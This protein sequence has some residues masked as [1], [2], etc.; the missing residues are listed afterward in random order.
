[1]AKYERTGN[2]TVPKW[3]LDK[4]IPIL[5]RPD[6]KQADVARVASEHAGRESPWG[7]DSISKF[8]AGTGRTAALT[9][10]ISAALHIPPPFFIAP[11][12]AAASAMTLIVERE[13]AKSDAESNTLR[14]FDRV[15]EK[16]MRSTAVDDVRRPVVVSV[17]HG[18]KTG[19]GGRAVRAGRGRS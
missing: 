2:P 19:R 9:N 1:M 5:E 18:D 3:W 7:R 12:E 6:I 15:A 11:S 17:D 10:G 16:E 4:A 8:V 13:L 14:A